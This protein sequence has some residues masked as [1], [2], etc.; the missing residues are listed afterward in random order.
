MNIYLGLYHDYQPRFFIYWTTDTCNNTGCY[1][2]RCGGFVQPSNKIVVEFAISRTSTSGGSQLDVLIDN[3]IFEPIGYSP[4][5]LFTLLTEYAVTVECGGE[6]VN[7]HAS[8]RHTSTQMGSGCYPGSGI[9]KVAYMRNL[10]IALS[11][12]E[13]QPVQDLEIIA[14]SPYYYG[15]KI[16]NDTFFYYRGPDHL[17]VI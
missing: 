4:S 10:Q 2:H 12:N 13:F 1:N 8:G 15:A 17:K 3:G 7:M 6:I 11:E 9:G 16:L 5:F 14:T